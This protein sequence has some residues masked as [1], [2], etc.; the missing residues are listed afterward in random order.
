MAQKQKREKGRPQKY[1]FDLKV[2]ESASYINVNPR[3]LRSAAWGWSQK[4]KDGRWVYSVNIDQKNHIK[5][6]LT[7]IK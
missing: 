7:R 6:I 4:Y 1:D 3:S 2:G 5:V